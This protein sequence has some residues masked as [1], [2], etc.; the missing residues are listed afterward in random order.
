MGSNLGVIDPEYLRECLA[1]DKASGELTW[2]SRPREHFATEPAS[3]I[4]NTKFAGSKALTAT[5][6]SGYRHG[7]INNR[8]YLAHRVIWSIVYG[9]WPTEDIDHING[10]RADNRIENLRAVSRAENLRNMKL[11][12]NNTTGVMGVYWHKNT[13]KWRSLIKVNG[14]S[15]H[16]GLF[17]SIE[18]AAAAR[19]EA[20]K[21]Y[22]FHPNHGRL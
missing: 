2:L 16:L 21:K 12:N 18:D 7:T 14:K 9:E 1:Y 5:H 11:Y 3:R 22:D 17:E 13:G 20:E 8:R 6:G 10:N 15:I 4:W 19:A